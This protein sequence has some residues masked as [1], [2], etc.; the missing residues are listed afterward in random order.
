[1]HSLLDVIAGV[2]YAL[3]ILALVIPFLDTIDRFQLTN[4]YSPFVTLSV[5]LL[6]CIFYPS[7][8]QWSTARGD[9]SI[10]VGTVCGLTIGSF[11]NYYFGYLY[12]PDEPPLYDI[13]PPNYLYVI[14]RTILGLFIF[15]LTRQFFKKFLLR[16]LCWLHNL[17][18]QNPEAKRIKKIELPYYY[19]TYLF[20]G[21]NITFTSPFFFRLF[22]IQR[23]YSF[24]EL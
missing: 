14:L 1:M 16:F 18:S 8:R 13:I 24:T 15:A 6:M 3:F 5:G 7:I 4:P 11:L 19:I 20:I 9:T 21:L 22:G 2:F 10:I 17:D 12:K 23:D